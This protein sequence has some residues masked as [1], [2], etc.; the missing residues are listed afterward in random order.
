MIAVIADDLTGAAEIGG[1]G[2]RY[3]LKAEIVTHIPQGSSADLLIISTDTRSMPEEAALE[4]TRDVS[5]AVRAINPSIVFKKVDSVMRGHIIPEIKLHLQVLGK[6]RALLAPANPGF[7]RKL[8]GGKYYVNDQLI[9]ETAFAHDPEF[10]AKGPQPHEMLR[11]Q[12]NEI[13]VLKADDEL[14][15]TGIIVGETATNADLTAWIKRAGQDTL[16]AGGAGLFV[17]LLESMQL[18]KT[19]HNTD[20]P[21][22]EPALFVCGTTHDK[23]RSRLKNLKAKE[24]P[25]SYMPYAVISDGTDLDFETWADEIISLLKKNKKAIIAID[26]S[27]TVNNNVTAVDLREKKAVIVDMVLKRILIKELLIEGG[28]TAAAIINRLK[29]DRFSPV[30]EPGAGVIKMNVADSDMLLTLK[31][32]SYDWPANTWTF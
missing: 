30:S 12:K 11:V 26:E 23:S 18:Q 13:A 2:L 1:I 3:G 25:V 32:G 8:T 7:G 4:L 19:V 27:S 9:H 20:I 28:S 10:P 14:P 16:L 21:V 24:G 15:S 17:A 22:Q 6:A 31:P 29:F 5:E